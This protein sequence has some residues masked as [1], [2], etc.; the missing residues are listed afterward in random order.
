[1]KINAEGLTS[2][3]PKM[4]LKTT[5]TWTN[6]QTF[7]SVTAT[8]VNIAG[9]PI[10][11]STWTSNG[12]DGSVIKVT[13]GSIAAN[14]SITISAANLKLSSILWALCGEVESVNTAVTSVRLKSLTGLPV[15]MV[16]YNAD[17]VNTKDFSCLTI[18][19]P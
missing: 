7:S 18:G 14:T 11:N 12:F 6:P 9:T 16:V 13:T 8:I 5:N 3:N 15:N 17:A 4:I 2:F 10:H 19:K 1:M